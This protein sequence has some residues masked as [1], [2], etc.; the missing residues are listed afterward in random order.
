MLLNKKL[1]PD[2]SGFIGFL[3]LLMMAI[4][5]PVHAQDKD[6]KDPVKPQSPPPSNNTGAANNAAAAPVTANIPDSFPDPKPVGPLPFPI[7]DRQGDFLSSGQRST[8]DFRLPSNITD[9]VG[10]DPATQTYTV[11]EKIGGKYYRTPVTY[12]AEEYWAMR[13]RQAEVDYWQK[14]ANTMNLLNRKIARPKL[15][16]YDNL[17]NRLFGNGKIEIAPQ[18]NVDIMAGYQGQNIKNPTLPERARKNGGLDFNMNAQVNVNAN[19]GDKLKF[20]IA[21]N[22]LANFGQENQLKLDYTG[23]DDEIIKRF[24]AG[25]V[26]FSSRSTFIPGSQQ[27]FGL[28]TQLQFGKLNVT[29]VIANQKSQRQSVNLQGGAAS[30]PIEVKADEYEENRH[31]LL[32]Q[33]FKDNYNKVLSKIPAVT[34]PVQILRLEVWVTN[35]NGTTVNT[36]DVV[37]FMDLGENNPYRSDIIQQQSTYANVPDNNANNL[38]SILRSNPAYRQPSTVFTSLQSYGLLPV[39]DYEKTYARKLDSTQYYFNRQAGYISLSQPLQA[40][41]VLAVAYQYSYNGHVYQVGEFSQDIT[42]DSTVATQQVLFLKL[43]KATSQRPNLPIWQWMMKNVYSVGYGTLSPQDFKINLLYQEPGQGWKRYV[44]FGDKNQGTPI[45]SLVN[46]DRLN[47]QNDPQP[48]G[49]F[50]FV[51]GYTV[52]SQYSR[53]VFPVLEPFGRDLASQI[54]NV[55]PSTAKD[56]LYYALYDT[57]KAVAQQYPNL[58]RFVLKGSARTSGSSDISIGYNIPKG[59]VTVTAGGQTLIEG[60]D[61]DINYD[62]G[63]I[64]VTNQA[65]L[66]AGLPV[67][68]NFENNAAFGIQQR[69][70]TALRLDYMAIDKLKEQLALGGTMVKLSER[71]FFTKNNLGEEPISNKMYGLDVSY[72]KELP[73][74]TKILDKLPFYSTTAPSSINFYAEGAMLKPGHAPQIGSGSAGTVYIDDFE[75]SR[76][77]IDL[78]FPAVSWAL[79]S[80]P[81]GATS[82]I[83]TSQILFPEALQPTAS[84]DYGKNRAKIAWYQ[85]EPALQQF[86]GANNPLGENRDE[87]SDPRSRLVQQ[88]EIFPQRTTDYGQNQ[89]TTFD[90]AYYPTEKGP[91]NFDNSPAS[92]DA[93][94]RLRNPTQKWGGLMRN[95]DQ[96]D[97]ETANIEFIEFWM[98]DPFVKFGNRDQT[99]S[100][101]GKL[102][103][104]LGNISE[105]ILKDGK[106]FYEN[107][108]PTPTSNQPTDTT[109]WGRVPLNPIQV[110]NAFSNEP[111]DR[112]YQD[113]GLDG[114]NNDSERVKFSPYLNSLAGM[115][116]PAALQ[117]VQNDPSQD[118]YVWYRDPAFGGQDGIV[119]R[120]KNYNGPQGN[121]AVSDGS[122]VFSSAATLYPDGE[123]INRDNTMN[124]TEQ[125]FQY[126][127]NIKP[128]TPGNGM[129][130][131]ENFIVDKKEVPITN[132]P[133]GTGRNEIWYQFRIPIGSFNKRVGNIPDFKSI[134]FIRMFLTGF[135]SSVVIR[136][137]SLQLT[138]NIWRTF[139]FKIDTTG[140]YNPITTNAD[141]DVNGVNIEENDK[142]DPLPY[143]TPKDIQ[144]QQIQSNNGVTLLQ[145]EQSMSLKFCNLEKGDSRGVQ[146]TF[147]NRDF[148][149]FGKLSMYIHAENAVKTPDAIRD[150]EL[151]AVIRIGSDFAGNYYEVK[152]PLHMTPLTAA[153]TLDP[154]SDAYNDTLWNALNSLDLD[155]TV[156]PKLKANRN[157]S[158]A[159]LNIPYP[160]LQPNGH[161]YSIMG[162][163]NLGEIH[164]ILIGV[165]NAKNP[166]ACGEIWVNEL[167]LTSI[168]EQ[169]GYAAMARADITLADLGTVTASIATHTTGFGT[170]E[171]RVNER[172]RDNMTQLDVSANIELGKLLPKKA[173]ISIPVFASYSQTVSNPEYDPFD[174]D[175]KLKDKLSAAQSSAQRDSIKN[176]AV[177]FTST[178]TVNFTNVR[179]NRTGTGNPKIYDISNFDISYSYFNTKAHNPLIES[180]EVTRHRGVLGYNFA[181]QPKYIEP[182]KNIKFFKKRKDHWFDLV[183]DFN[184]NYAP[185]Q[186]SFRT[187]IQRQ[188]GAIRPRSIGSDKYQIPET[189]D[190]Y[191]VL[192][193]DYILRW[194]FTRSFAF[195]F[196]ATNNSRVDEPY[197]RLDTKEKRDT[198]W[199]N[200]LNGGRNTLYNHTANFSYTLPTT[201]FP[202]TDWTAVN[203]KYQATY[204]W[205]GASRLAVEL[206]NILENSQTKEATVQ[207]DFTKLYNKFKFFRALDQPPGQNTKASEP[208]TRTD[209]V[210]RWVK[211]DGIKVKEVKKLKVKKIKDPNALPNLGLAA[212]IFGRLV[213]SVKQ[214]SVSVSDNGNTRLPGYMDSTEYIGQNWKSMEP[215]LDFVLGMQPDTSWLNRAAKR[216]LISK[217]SMFNTIFQQSYNQRLALTAQVEPV[218]DL[219]ISVNL[220]KTFSKNYSELFKDT[221]ATGLNFGHL[222]PYSGGSFD[223]SFIALKTMFGKFDPNQLSS[224]FLQF[225][226]NRKVISQRLG[227]ANK[228]NQEGAGGATLNPDAEGYYYGYGKYATDVLIPAFIAAYTGKDP[229]KIGLIDQSNSKISS[230]P[231]KRFLPMPNWKVDYTGLSRIKGLD[232]IFSNVTL[233]HGYTGDLSMNGFNSALLYEDVSRY[234]YPSFYDTASKNYVPYFLIP[235]ITIQEQFGPLFGI[236]MMFTNQLQAKVE[237]TKQRMLSLSLVDFQLSETRSTEYTIGGGYRKKGLK[238]P[239]PLP[240][241][242]AGKNGGNKLENEINFRFDFRIRDNVTI[243]NRLDQEATLP[244]SGSKEVTLSPSIDYFVSSRVNVKLFFD[245]RKVTPYISSSPP[246]TNTRAGL[247]VRIS[248]AQ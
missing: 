114:M 183:K 191:L 82:D 192:Q 147:A 112:P 27:L 167:R 102:Y 218:R 90:L 242:L 30:Q 72:R 172:Y 71:P 164:G 94:N 133:N 156:L 3:G 91:Y 154:N 97:F 234:S 165:E 245:Q 2:S 113:V 194:N 227:L 246:T 41:E 199:R 80:T 36:R 55:V 49:V 8:Y 58:N 11:Y 43:L 187:D 51:E 132:L 83:D 31:F 123:D 93:N 104:N 143:R 216:N 198:V 140:N 138:R 25:V 116:N 153:H 86:R 96:T 203:L 70:Y 151:N 32:G 65:I 226:E 243:N 76:S 98:Q 200:L 53:I 44:P 73:R 223:I 1:L 34:T 168:N 175:I 244:T 75:G 212:R 125:Y 239:F 9:S 193:R 7:N 68:V 106:R 61:Y 139:Q 145:N 148:R 209:T 135:D 95:I 21:Y 33:Y 40:D 105:D 236:D 181:P 220:T 37:G 235:N 150:G 163:P 18:G 205:I 237:V 197:G 230:N 100:S 169:G 141:F 157:S 238:F 188:F 79:A 118:D 110:T 152:I 178:T 207:L 149:Q 158:G 129:D 115:L 19:I 231:F 176:A 228:Y 20:P 29:A 214:V 38:F 126:T 117:Q 211:K 57:I 208:R 46:L 146:Q 202:V 28:K 52:L 39:Q 219:T 13:G 229:N 69:N 224:T 144:R 6:K 67:Q 127:V 23:Q 179:K 142:R 121:S 59:S 74:L 232:K 17:F 78:R 35:K 85:I 136:F 213:S 201:K 122:S 50:D 171:Q 247:Q 89:L 225:Q 128:P 108:L 64:K 206:G 210:Y 88:S 215:G 185:S 111:A 12:T 166:S 60:T 137:G 221:T 48:D 62:L 162:D 233:S 124:E 174:M 77:G 217:D 5:V 160:Q 119:Q 47:N 101:G 161:T 4:A 241:F 134:R 130:I 196:T 56:T 107:G 81:Q 42:P 173:A 15:S 99:N 14:R 189:Y 180:N 92:V 186:L 16:L 87:L 22:T 204:R 63:T 54:Y 109:I 248:L 170:L 182:F 24:E 195:D 120:Y 84:L 184:F 190:K 103:F 26:Q 66:N 131:G 155:L 45:L 240:K 10:Y 222:S 177:D 159:P